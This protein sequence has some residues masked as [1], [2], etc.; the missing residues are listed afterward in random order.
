MR[1]ARLF[2]QRLLL[3]L[4]LLLFVAWLQRPHRIKLPTAG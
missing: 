3:L 2:A 1:Q 4:L